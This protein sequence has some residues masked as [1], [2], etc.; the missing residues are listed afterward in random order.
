MLRDGLM[1]R[2]VDPEDDGRTSTESK[3]FPTT[4]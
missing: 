2:K 4:P 3:P 1:R